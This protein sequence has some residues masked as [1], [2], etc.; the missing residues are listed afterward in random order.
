M[1]INYPIK[2]AAMP[3]KEQVGWSHGLDELER[4]CDIVCYIVSKCYLIGDLTK[5]TEDGKSIKQYEV[6]FPYQQSSFSGWQWVT[7]TYNVMCGYCTNGNKVDAIFDSYEDAQSF[8]TTKNGELCKNSYIHLLCSKDYAA[9][10]EAKKNEFYEK[11]TEYQLLEEQ[12]LLHT[13]DMEIG[14]NKV[15]TN[16]IKIENNNGVILPWSIYE[17][18]ELFVDDKFVVYSVSQEQYCHLTN[19][20]V[21]EK[22]DDTKS[23]IGPEQGLVIHKTKDDLIKLAI[24]EVC[25]AYYIQSDNINYDNKLDKVT[26]EAFEDIDE[27][28]LIFYTTET[29]EDLLRSY[30]KHSKIDLRKVHEPVLK[31]TI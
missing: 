24:Q 11:L 30:K 1:K 13:E 12:I 7:P 6:V 4:K 14:K 8:V 18:L 10:K 25:G 5:Y 3:I 20:I 31:K 2:Y 15:L 17:I 26:P 29:I 16:V 9:K 27:D 21:E 19:L 28:T 23:I 22:I